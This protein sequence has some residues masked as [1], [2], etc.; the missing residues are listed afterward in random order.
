MY[1]SH[2]AQV[3]DTAQVTR[4]VLLLELIAENKKEISKH[5]SI[6]YNMLC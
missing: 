1:I 5:I 3:S 2:V 4:Q 6:A